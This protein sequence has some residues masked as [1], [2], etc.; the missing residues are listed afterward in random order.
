MLMS[1]D[2]KTVASPQLYQSKEGKIV[3]IQELDTFS[4]QMAILKTFLLKTILK[5][6]INMM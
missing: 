1:N 3:L 2:F 5:E 4:F 6:I